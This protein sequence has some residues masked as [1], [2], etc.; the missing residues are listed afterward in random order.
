MRKKIPT[1]ILRLLGSKGTMEIL[2]ELQESP[3]HFNELAESVRVSQRPI[4]PRTLN[5]RLR[6]LESAHLVSR[7]VLPSRPPRTLYRISEKGT[8]TLN[9][10]LG[11][12]Q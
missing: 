10:V 11:L 1:R 12:Q 2:L 9:R 8:K 5:R 7:E 4:S 6:E 3:K